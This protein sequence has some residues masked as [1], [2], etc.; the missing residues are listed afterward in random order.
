[1]LP[2]PS[3]VLDEMLVLPLPA[4]EPLLHILPPSIR[5]LL[6]RWS[7][8]QWAPL[9]N[10]AGAFHGVDTTDVCIISMPHNAK[11]KFSGII[12]LANLPNNCQRQRC[13][14]TRKINATIC[15]NLQ[16]YNRTRGVG[17]LFSHPVE[18]PRRSVDPS[19]EEAGNRNVDFHGRRHFRALVCQYAHDEICGLTEIPFVGRGGERN[20]VRWMR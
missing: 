2:L 1:M 11:V 9:W 5:W 13:N 18:R 6:R 12:S 4:Q 14:V 19:G 16:Q 15:N 10:A 20:A 17:C 8:L 3:L 7:N